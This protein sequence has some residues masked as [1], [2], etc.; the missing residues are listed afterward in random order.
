MPSEILRSFVKGLSME[1][2]DKFAL[3]C[4]H[5]RHRVGPPQIVQLKLQPILT[6]SRASDGGQVIAVIS[7][8]PCE[9]CT[10]LI[11]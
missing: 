3:T 6:V 10:Y 4:K 5:V 1:D 2:Y 11:G 7:P 8:F 9:M